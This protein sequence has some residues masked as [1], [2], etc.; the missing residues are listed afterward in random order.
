MPAFLLPAVTALRSLSSVQ[1]YL[2]AGSIGLL[3]AMAGIIWLQSH[4]L[5]NRADTI[6]EL[7]NALAETVQANQSN[8]TTIDTLEARLARI[9][10]GARLRRETQVQA[11]G[12]MRAELERQAQSATLLREQ[13]NDTITDD[14]RACTVPAGTWRVLHET[15]TGGDHHRDG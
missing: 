6:A 3:V 13:L 5:D 2:L 9:A 15:A 12:A 1:K 4:R 10:A 8:Q 14:M 11:L 7:R